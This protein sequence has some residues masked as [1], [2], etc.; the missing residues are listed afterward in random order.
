MHLS[1]PRTQ[2]P[3]ARSGSMSCGYRTSL[4]MSCPEQKSQPQ[5]CKPRRRQLTR[6]GGG[7]C[8]NQSHSPP[9]RC[10]RALGPQ[11]YIPS[12][13]CWAAMMFGFTLFSFPRTKTLLH[14][15][16]VLPTTLPQH[17]F[18]CGG[19][20]GEKA[21]SQTAFLCLLTEDSYKLTVPFQRKK[22]NPN[23]VCTCNCFSKPFHHPQLTAL[24][25]P[26][27]RAEILSI[28]PMS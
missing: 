14:V 13:Q 15:L 25:T 18:C 2:S 11:L 24:Q 16:A 12:R 8:R 5:P 3:W 17:H 28:I 9:G 10:H 20:K 26:N 1:A 23:E 27:W 7:P 22:K 6:V 4:R 19:S 21:I